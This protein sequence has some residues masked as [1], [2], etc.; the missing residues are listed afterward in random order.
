MKKAILTGM[1]FGRLTVKEFSHVDG[2]RKAH[3]VCL[4]RCGRRVTVRGNSLKQG[5]TRS[6]GCL[7]A[8]HRQR[9][10]ARPK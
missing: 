6:C 3:W 7:A 10:G 2:W 1:N 5:G 9:T 4:C 8:K